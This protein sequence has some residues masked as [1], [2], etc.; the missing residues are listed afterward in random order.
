MA[1]RD[2]YE[3][4]GLSKGAGADEIKKAY[5][6]MALKYHP[7]KNPG[8]QEAEEK[9][10]E[11]AEAYE[12][13][14]NPE[15]KQRYDQFGHQGV[16]GN[17]GFGGGGGMNMDDIFSQFGDIFGGGGGF[18]SFFGG[19]R[20]GGRR[21][22]KGTNLRVKLKVNLKEVANGVEKKIKVKRHMVADGVSFKTCSTCQGSGQVKKVVNTMLGQMVS[23]SACPNCGG[24]GQIID[25]KPD[26]ADARGLILKE[27]VIPINIPAGVADGMQLSLSGK[28]N[29]IPGGV[30]GDL[31]IV[32]EEIEHDILQRDGNN[33]VYDLY[34]NFV[35][36]ALGA[37]IE[38]PTIESK[39]KIKLEPGTQSGKILR[40]KGKGIKDL[41]GFG[42][43]DELIH[44]N[45]WTPQQ[46][47]KE[48]KEKLESLRESENFIPAP[49]KSEKTFFDKMKEFF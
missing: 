14:S 27:E 47:T 40:L 8:D 21:M 13:L 37:H 43:G 44:V 22:R 33:V 39:V 4:L 23:A 17:G 36:A 38:V 24:T 45:V 46:L 35:D 7:D 20:G 28:G 3:V 48:E 11:A 19:G 49:G 25:K 32:I 34:V 41:N 16:S 5:R 10:K 6:K 9:F 1:K 31:L 42:R 29:E 18:E 26:H 15:K 12:V 30:A 2:Y